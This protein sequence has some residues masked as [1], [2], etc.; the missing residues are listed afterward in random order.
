MASAVE[1]SAG[2]WWHQGPPGRGLAHQ[3]SPETP[4]PGRRGPSCSLLVRA[5]ACLGLT[6]T[7][8]GPSSARRSLSPLCR[9]IGSGE[10]ERPNLEALFLKSNATVT[11]H[12]DKHPHARTRATPLL[13]RSLP[14][15]RVSAQ[16]SETR[17]TAR[18]APG[19]PTETRRTARTAPGHPTEQQRLA[20]T[21]LREKRKGQCGPCRGHLA[22]GPGPLPTGPGPR[23]PPDQGD[24]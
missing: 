7:L 12:T 6:L 18:T 1:A 24:G 5:R 20:T 19:H 23:S 15:A 13:E 21:R 2:F 8:R 17:R 11:Y 4:R 3:A 16:H 10:A 22:Q 9:P 14:R